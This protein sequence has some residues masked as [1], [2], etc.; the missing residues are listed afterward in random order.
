MS[1]MGAK[2]ADFGDWLV[3]QVQPCYKVYYDHGNSSS[4]NVASIKG[5]IGDEPVS[6]RNR[7]TDVDLMI[8]EG[9]VVRVLIEIEERDVSPKKILGSLTASLICDRFAVRDKSGKQL[10]F[11]PDQETK[12]IVVGIAPD[13]GH[14]IEKLEKLL[15]LRINQLCAIPNC[16]SGSNAKIIIK[17]DIEQAIEALK[18]C[19]QPWLL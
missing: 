16:V 1:K 12:F 4:A 8:V 6:N 9:A 11:S 7:I 3:D 10:Y 19:L 15:P 5:F 2:T 17:P 14:R 13:N 18:E